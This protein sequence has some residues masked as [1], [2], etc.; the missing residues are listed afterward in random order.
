MVRLNKKGQ[1]GV[2]AG[3]ISAV[4]GIV[5]LGLILVYGSWDKER[6]CFLLLIYKGVVETFL[7]LKTEGL[8]S[9]IHKSHYNQR[10]PYPYLLHTSQLSYILEKHPLL[11]L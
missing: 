1:Y 11:N 7:S 3:I 8:L 6:H 2:L 5:V 10:S 4:G 9:P